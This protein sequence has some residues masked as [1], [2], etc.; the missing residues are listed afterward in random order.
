MSLN[1]GIIGFG[2]HGH[3]LTQACRRVSGV[4]VRSI[5]RRDLA[6]AEEA[7]ARLGVI[8]A[9]SAEEMLADPA[10]DAVMVASPAGSHRAY[11]EQALLAG[12]HVLV[13][14]PLADTLEDGQAI[15]SAAQRSDRILM[16]NHC[17]RFNP[18]FIDAKRVVQDGRIGE[19][20]A[21]YS[22]RLSPLHLNN[23]T[24]K[25]G[26]MDTAVHN[27]DLA[28]W[29]M[30]AAPVRVSARAARVHPES[31]IDDCVWISMEFP[32]GRRAEDHIAW[33]PMDRYLMPVA[34][35]RFVLLGSGGF[36]QV[37]LWRR[38]GML[39]QGECSR[40]MD[41]V[42][43][44]ESEEYF[45]TM[46][47][48]VLRFLQAVREGRPS[49]MPACQALNALRVALAARESIKRNGAEVTLEVDN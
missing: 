44:G 49:P 34:H 6:A 5:F 32:G 25:L 33:V 30:E 38:A 18:A 9:R 2:E 47:H 16:V 15:V 12:K 4:E 8:A 39:Y 46:A 48:S 13:E 26:V 35:P 11:C 3:F 29:L 10:I 23:P 24:W 45:S 37:D 17:E 20:R 1:V 22:T 7:A 14:K 21:L 27:L 41:D 43:L 40:Y 42:L 36:Y 19:L 31:G 28:C